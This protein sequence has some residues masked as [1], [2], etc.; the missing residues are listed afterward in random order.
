MSV[1]GSPGLQ[2]QIEHH[3]FPRV[4]RHNLREV[5]R[6]VKDFCKREGLYH[7]SVSFLQGNKEVIGG[8]YQTALAARELPRDG[9]SL[10]RLKESWTWEMF[11]AEG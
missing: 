8:L 5:Q 6:M 1:C 10:E 3:L 7:H 4:P 11:N 9:K 2:F